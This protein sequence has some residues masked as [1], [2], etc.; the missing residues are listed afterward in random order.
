[1]RKRE[2]NLMETDARDTARKQITEWLLAI[3]LF[4]FKLK[5][6][7][8]QSAPVDVSVSGELV[9]EWESNDAHLTSDCK[10]SHFL[11]IQCHSLRQPRER[12]CNCNFTVYVYFTLH[13]V[14]LTAVWVKDA[15]WDKQTATRVLATLRRRE[16]ER[17]S[18][19]IPVYPCI[20]TNILVVFNE[21]SQGYPF[22]LSFTWSTVM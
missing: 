19:L 7:R 3:K 15:A 16:R 13:W 5:C 11:L 12:K 22:F 1:M 2:I 10:V 20:V 21:Y 9:R 17:E 8:W 4:T 14:N 18:A 6:I